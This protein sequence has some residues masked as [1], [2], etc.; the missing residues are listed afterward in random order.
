M[1]TIAQLQGLS[2]ETLEIGYR[3][4]GRLIALSLDYQGLS[5]KKATL[6][7]NNVYRSG[8]GVGKMTD[9]HFGKYIKG[10][11]TAPNYATLCDISMICYKPSHFLVT[12]S[13]PIGQPVIKVNRHDSRDFMIYGTARKREDL[14]NHEY[15]CTGSDLI[16]IIVSPPVIQDLRG[17]TGSRR[18]HA[19]I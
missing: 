8:E 19:Y 15:R 7:I 4:L 1:F 13:D 2:D 9:G 14:P 16:S 5:A 11:V 18:T 10:H 3:R 6:L 12:Q 17:D